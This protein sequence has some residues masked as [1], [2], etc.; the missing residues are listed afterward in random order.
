MRT[1]AIP[2]SLA[3]LAGVLAAWLGASV[4]SCRAAEITLDHGDRADVDLAVRDATPALRLLLPEAI[5]AE[6]LGEIGGVHG[7]AGSWVEDERAIQG[8]IRPRPDA[9]CLVR[10]EPLER[11]VGIA[12]AVKNLS[13]R[14]WTDVRL[15]ICANLCRLPKTWKAP[16]SNR[17]F[18]P[19]R[20]PLDRDAQGRYWYREAT[21][22]GLQAWDPAR[23][24]IPM[25]LRPD[26]PDP[27]PE[28]PY[29][30]ELSA[31]D[32]SVACAI[33]SLDGKRFAYMVWRARRSRHQ[34]PF[35]GNACMHLR[36]QAAPS[37]A[38]GETATL[39]G[40]A[41][42]FE[43]SR[44]DLEEHLARVSREAPPAGG[45]G[46]PRI[47]KHGT[48]DLDLVE[49]T[50]IVFRGRPLRFE[51]VRAGY[52]N[53]A[54]KE[55]HFRFVDL[56][57]GSATRPFARGYAFG[58]AFVEGDTVYV[59]GTF[60]NREVHVFA[61]RDLERWETWPAI[62]ESGYGI[63]NT[64]VAKAGDEY[65]LMFEID[66]PAEEAGVPFTARFARSRD[67]RSWTI[68]P[69]ECCYAKDRYSAPHCLRYH[70]GWFYDFY[71]EAHRGYEMRV[72]RSRDLV[73]WE[74][75]PLR[76]VLRAS[77]E[78]KLIANPALTEAQREK[79]RAAENINN[80]DLDICEWNGRLLITYSWGDQRG[81]EFLAEAS[82]EGALGEFLRGWF[83]P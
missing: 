13:R 6:G 49:T 55:N 42:I 25:H 36:P 12:I 79:I 70:D 39:F 43:G 17:D 21:P 19:E 65:V 27:L 78:D 28:N 15:D 69:P 32:A 10:L 48:V 14:T 24:W 59:T 60:E 76:P 73:R 9:A 81:T 53:N 29:H 47:L 68:A 58:N 80:S 38:P 64:S 11:A 30:A 31:T 20:I 77:P 61:S 23:G 50:P 34:S 5:L 37:L 54:L 46:R 66:R 4:A 56:A 33:P 51:W 57:D 35:S 52:W 72:V 45:D 71:L 7:A 67:L 2:R 26:S 1:E 44:E 82:Y 40:E 16:W 75:S 22:R 3:P 41:G 62:A 63:Y 83:P 74:P 8:W 18:I